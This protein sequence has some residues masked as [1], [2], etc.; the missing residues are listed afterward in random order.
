MLKFDFCFFN[1][2]VTDYLAQM[3]F[4]PNIFRESYAHFR[5]P[6]SYFLRG[7]REISAAVPHQPHSVDVLHA[8]FFHNIVDV[9]QFKWSST[10]AQGSRDNGRFFEFILYIS[11]A[12]AQNDRV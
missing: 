3:A 1:T 11:G 5:P 4:P 12:S 6:D 2:M 9:R 8:I 7:I 10:G